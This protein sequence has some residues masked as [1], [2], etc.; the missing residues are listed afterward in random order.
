ML[1]QAYQA[2]CDALEPMRW[3]ARGAMRF[4]DD[5]LAGAGHLPLTRRMFALAEVFEQAKITHKRPPYAIREVASGNAAVNVREEVV[6][7]L[8]FGDLLHFAKNDIETPQPRILLVAPLSGHFATLLRDTAQTL[9][10]DHDVYVTDW[11]NARDVPASAG[12]FGFDDYVDY[13]IRFL[14]ELGPGS[15]VLAV[16]QPCVQ[17]LAA[18]A[19][20][21]MD[22]DPCQPRSMTLMGGPIDTRESPTEVNELATNQTYEWFED[23]LI[24][25][26]P[27][28]H[29]GGGRKVYPGFIQ[30][31][32]F[33]SMNMGRHMGQFRKLYQ[34]LA[35]QDTSEVQRIEEFYEEYFA[36]LDIPA[37][38]YLET[39]DRVFQRALLA[40]GE[41]EHRGRTVDC[42]A[43]RKTALLTVEGERD[44]ICA[45]GQTA[46]AHLLCTSLRPHLKRHHLQTG[47]GHYGIFSGS[48]W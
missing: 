47:A 30:L 40:K 35:D 15:H 22:D 31:T 2:Y 14:H 23:N 19:L 44:D 34:A 7:S 24:Q 29:R 8:P 45:V 13:V 42:N 38:F 32:A 27:L 28:R 20:M 46:A 48:R 4:R 9:L 43:I 17:V 5:V 41:L 26:V 11:T 1:Y 25:I 39:V 21:A 18:V 3:A 36:V 33:M 6:L 10:K 12:P 37:E 16:C